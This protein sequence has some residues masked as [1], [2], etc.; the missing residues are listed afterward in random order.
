MNADIADET[1]ADTTSDSANIVASLDSAKIT[2]PIDMSEADLTVNM[3]EEI[4][5][6][7]SEKNCFFL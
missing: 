4:S 7:D 2:P 1:V 3:A 5:S 6:K